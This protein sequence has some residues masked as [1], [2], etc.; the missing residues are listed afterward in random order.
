MIFAILLMG[1]FYTRKSILVP[2]RGQMI[3]GKAGKQMSQWKPE[4]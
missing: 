3:W 2:E 1:W 4:S